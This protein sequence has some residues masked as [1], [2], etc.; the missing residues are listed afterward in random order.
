MPIN[1]LVSGLTSVAYLVCLLLITGV[2]AVNPV[3][4]KTDI[5]TGTNSLASNTIR[6]SEPKPYIIGTNNYHLA[7]SGCFNDLFFNQGYIHSTDGTQRLVINPGLSDLSANLLALKLLTP[8]GLLATF[9]CSGGVNADLFQ[10]IVA[11]A[12]VDAGVNAQILRRLGPSPRAWSRHRR[13]SFSSARTGLP[14][15]SSS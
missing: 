10:K 6:L 11:G 15:S 8:G 12:A 5:Y 3:S 13:F 14:A 7:P 4:T 9:S 2:Q 1:P